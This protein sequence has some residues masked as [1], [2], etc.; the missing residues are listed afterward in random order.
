MVIE[1]I[2]K[3]QLRLEKENGQPVMKMEYKGVKMRFLF[4]KEA[5]PINTKKVVVDMLI[6]QYAAD[7]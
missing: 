4:A 5:P 7:T 2:E 1:N 6:S 3:Q